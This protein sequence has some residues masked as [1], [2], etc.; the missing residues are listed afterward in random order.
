MAYINALLALEREFAKLTPEECF[1][2][3][4][5]KSKPIS[6]AFFA[7]AE[8]LNALPKVP[9]GEDVGYAMSQRKYLENAFCDGRTEISNNRAERSVKPFVMGRK[10]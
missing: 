6:D 2:V 1:E 10:A 5:E 4:L 3:H 7:W 9:F 8:S